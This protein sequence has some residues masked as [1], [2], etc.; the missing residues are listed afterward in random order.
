L[1]SRVAYTDPATEE[2]TYF[3]PYG[4][5]P[6]EETEES[7][8]SGTAGIKGEIGSWNYDVASTYGKDDIDL[9]TRDSANASLIAATGQ[10][11]TNFYDGTYTATQWTTNLDITKDFDVG[12]AKPLTFAF[13]AEYRKET[14]EAAPGDQASRYLEGG[15][16]FPGLSTSDSGSHDRDVTAGYVDFLLKPI[17]KLSLDLAGR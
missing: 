10:T 12:M 17:D 8:Y 3:R 2:V 5:D 16:S 7:D 1:P 4:F 11:P 13:G 15:Q 6:R 14:W 9:F